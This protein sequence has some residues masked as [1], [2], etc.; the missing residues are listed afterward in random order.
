MT[1]VL[2]IVAALETE[3]RWIS[4]REIL[5]E[6]SGVGNIRAET[7]ARRLL[8]RGATALVSWGVAGGL[9][10]DLTPGT[11]VL[12]DSVIGPDGSRSGVDLEWRSRLLVRVGDRVLTSTL[13]LLETLQPITSPDEKRAAH[14]RT[15][16]GAVDM[17]SAAVAAV[18][19]AAGMSF[20]A[21]RVVV[22]GA[23]VRFPAAALTMCD[24]EGRLKR[25]SLFRM[26]VRPGNWGPLIGLAR[27]NAA[28][29]RAMR[30]LWSAGTPDLALSEVRT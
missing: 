10:P 21:V 29:G 22:D 19:N 9:D 28:A 14:R 16:A 15:G 13:P 23:D 24:E 30:S 2:G 17:E 8:E 27:A 12:P 6:V 5:T 26:V 25:S 3:R 11:V 7:A 4:A 18:A 20:I 1:G